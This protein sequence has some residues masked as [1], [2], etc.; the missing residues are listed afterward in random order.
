MLDFWNNTSCWI[1]GKARQVL[2][3]YSDFLTFKFVQN[4]GCVTDMERMEL[5]GGT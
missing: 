3:K 1:F 5:K 4:Y 2:F